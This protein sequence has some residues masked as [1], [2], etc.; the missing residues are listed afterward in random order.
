MCYNIETH[1]ENT[2]KRARHYG[3]EEWIRRI[4]EALEPYKLNDYQ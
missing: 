1:L 3:D 4:E 2:L